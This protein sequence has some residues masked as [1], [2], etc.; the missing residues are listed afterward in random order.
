MQIQSKMFPSNQRV[1][2]LKSQAAAA[3][4]QIESAPDQ[5]CFE[6][7]GTRQLLRKPDNVLQAEI[8]RNGRLSM[9]TVEDGKT[10]VLRSET[11]TKNTGAWQAAAGAVAGLVGGLLLGAGREDGRPGFGGALA[12]ALL[13]G[14]AGWGVGKA[15]EARAEQ[16]ITRV[17]S[18]ATGVTTERVTVHA[19]GTT[20]YQQSWKN[21]GP[22]TP[23]DPQAVKDYLDKLQL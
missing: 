11:L 10:V 6:S 3:R 13:G 2:E 18:D 23:P 1:D 20:D 22:Q 7:G 15:A 8:G 9:V 5:D 17:E 12:G 19:D 16:L 4:Q 21:T 14:A